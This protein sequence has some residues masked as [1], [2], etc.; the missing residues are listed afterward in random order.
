MYYTQVYHPV[1]SPVYF[2]AVCFFGAF[3]VI[4]LFLVVM[5]NS[6]FNIQTEIKKE[7]EL[8]AEVRRPPPAAARRPTAAQPPTAQRSG[9]PRRRWRRSS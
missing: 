2:A 3:F 7:R 1:A 4:N 8:L 9:S 6:Y 5:S